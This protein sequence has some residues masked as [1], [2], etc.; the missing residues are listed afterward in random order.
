MNFFAPNTIP[1]SLPDCEILHPTIERSR[2]SHQRCQRDERFAL[3]TTPILGV[4]RQKKFFVE[5]LF[6]KVVAKSLTGAGYAVSTDYF[7]S[8]SGMIS[9]VDVFAHAGD[10][11]N[12]R[13]IINR[14]KESNPMYENVLITIGDERFANAR[15]G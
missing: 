2:S 15:A 9:S 10:E 7:S 13:D 3:P 8:A 6:S 12:V 4:P 1:L 14:V 5:Q 11:G